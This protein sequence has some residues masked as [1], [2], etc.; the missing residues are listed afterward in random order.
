[1]RSSVKGPFKT[2]IEAV[3]RDKFR[4]WLDDHPLVKHGLYTTR[5]IEQSRL[6]DEYEQTCERTGEYR[7]LLKKGHRRTLP[8][9]LSVY[10]KSTAVL[11]RNGRLWSGHHSRSKAYVYAEHR[12]EMTSVR[13]GDRWK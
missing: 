5:Q 7:D 2:S 8:R 6:D 12:A 9:L 11:R 4:S 3:V 13:S 10:L 1:M